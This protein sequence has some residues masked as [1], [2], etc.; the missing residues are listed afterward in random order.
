MLGACLLKG[1][2]TSLGA[3]IATADNACNS[4]KGSPLSTK[5]EAATT[6][7]L[8]D[9]AGLSTTRGLGVKSWNTGRATFHTGSIYRTVGL[10]RAVGLNCC[11]H[12][13]KAGTYLIEPRGCPAGPA[14][15][16]GRCRQHLAG[17]EVAITRV[18]S[19]GLPLALG[20]AKKALSACHIGCPVESGPH[21][22][23]QDEGQPVDL[24]TS[25][26]IMVAGSSRP[27]PRLY[28]VASL[29]GY[30]DR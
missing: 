6:N 5:Q 22:P 15:G 23:V 21:H 14:T 1:G 8:T 18:G 12:R 25:L 28:W 10:Y 27:A 29:P 3:A 26:P 4:R 9:Q 11:Q 30:R 13:V 20:L 7:K 19:T 16:V 2:H 24:S 17:W